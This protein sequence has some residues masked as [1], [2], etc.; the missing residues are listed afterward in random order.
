MQQV[1]YVDLDRALGDAEFV[2][3]DLVAVAGGDGFQDLAFA[4]GEVDL[5]AGMGRAQCL[6]KGSG[7]GRADH[8]AAL[9]GVTNQLDQ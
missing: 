1:F 8:Q 2:A 7:Q 9:Q 4:F 3:D 6:G 5:C